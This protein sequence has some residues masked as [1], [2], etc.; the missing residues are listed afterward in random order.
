MPISP[1]PTSPARTFLKSRSGQLTSA[2]LT[3]PVRFSPEQISQTPT[4]EAL[5]SAVQDSK[6]ASSPVEATAFCRVA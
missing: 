6:P 5:T 4:F 1:A 3:S 2:A